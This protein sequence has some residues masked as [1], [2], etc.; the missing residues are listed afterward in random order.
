MLYVMLGQNKNFSVVVT[1]WDFFVMMKLGFVTYH[2][3]LLY[4]SDIKNILL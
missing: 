3:S 2:V 1:Q 4:S